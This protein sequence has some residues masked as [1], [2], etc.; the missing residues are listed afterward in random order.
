MPVD[1]RPQGAHRPLRFGINSDA[2]GKFD[3]VCNWI[4]VL[5]GCLPATTSG[6]LLTEIK[7]EFQG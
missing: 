3:A 5:K 2:S 6:T 7:R 1:D 4:G